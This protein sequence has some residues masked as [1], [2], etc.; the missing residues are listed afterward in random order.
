MK[1]DTT[2]GSVSFESLKGELETNPSNFKYIE[3]KKYNEEFYKFVIETDMKNLSINS[4]EQMIES[5]DKD[6]FDKFSVEMKIDTLAILKS[7]RLF[8]EVKDEFLLLKAVEK[9][10]M[11]IKNIDSDLKTKEFIMKAITLNP[12][13]FIEIDNKFRKDSDIQELAVRLEGKNLKFLNGK[14]QSEDSFQSQNLIKLA[15]LQD[16]RSISAINRGL[17]IELEKLVLINKNNI[18][19]LINPS[20]EIKEFYSN[21]SNLYEKEEDILLVSY[22]EF[23]EQYLKLKNSESIYKVNMELEKLNPDLENKV[24]NEYKMLLETVYEELEVLKDKMDSSEISYD[25]LVESFELAKEEGSVIGFKDIHSLKNGNTQH[26][27]ES[28]ERKIKAE[29]ENKLKEKFG[30]KEVTEED[31]SKKE[32]ISMDSLLKLNDK[33]KELL[34]EGEMNKDGKFNNIGFKSKENTKKEEKSSIMSSIKNL[35]SRKQK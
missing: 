27:K 23:S 7:K 30:L 4:K 33:N 14:E 12:K 15:I 20:S 28:E 26:L 6:T 32:E 18:K 34:K 16:S 19:N 9:N 35:I 5:I 24:D 10:P 17:P 21:G 8:N 25:R 29:A 3:L 13:V 22:F 11:V 1:I 31:I 2:Q